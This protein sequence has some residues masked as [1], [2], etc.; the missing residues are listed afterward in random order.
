MTLPAP[1][2]D[3]VLMLDLEVEAPARAKI[4]EDAGAAIKKQ[5]ELLRHDEWGRRELTYPID[6]KTAA[7][8]HLLQFHAGSPELLKGLDRSLRIADE[9]I[10]FRIVK[11]KPGTPDAPDMHAA[12]ATSRTAEAEVRT[13]TEAQTEVEAV[14]EAEVEVEAEVA[15]ESIAEGEIV[16]EPTVEGEIVVEPTPAPQA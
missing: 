6:H 9:V 14:V 8:Y 12:P 7:E 16:S 11:L 3:L 10:R 2:Y 4:L 5:G 13:D 15:V 1:T